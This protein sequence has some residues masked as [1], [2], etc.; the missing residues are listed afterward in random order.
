MSSDKN[1]KLIIMRHAKSDWSSDFETDFDRPLSARGERD[2][3]KIGDW[4]AEQHLSLDRFISSPAKRAKQ[5]ALIVAGKYGK[6]ADDIIWDDDIYDASLGQLLEV[7]VRHAKGHHCMILIG[8]NPGLDS[9]LCYLCADDAK[10]TPSGKL[11]TTSAVAMLDYNSGVILTEPGS[12]RLD[13][14]MRP[15]QLP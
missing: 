10:T 2:A 14:L 9:L 15:K 11:M 1:H 4:L 12:A 13:R 5:T 7:I 8:H 3:V 6:G